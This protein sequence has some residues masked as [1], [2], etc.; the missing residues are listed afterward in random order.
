MDFL[1]ILVIHDYH[2]SMTSTLRSCM[3]MSSFP[4]PAELLTATSTCTRFC[5]LEN[6]KH[7]LASKRNVN[8][9]CY[10]P[11][12]STKCLQQEMERDMLL[13][14][15]TTGDIRVKMGSLLVI[16]TKD[17]S[18]STSAGQLDARRH[19]HKKKGSS[20]EIHHP[21]LQQRTKL[22]SWT[23]L[24][25][26]PIRLLFLLGSRR[27]FVTSSIQTIF[28]VPNAMTTLKQWSTVSSEKESTCILPF[29][30]P[31][32]HVITCPSFMW[33]EIHAY[34]EEFTLFLLWSMK[35]PMKMSKNFLLAKT[36]H[37]Q[38]LVW[39]ETLKW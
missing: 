33:L 21:L 23:G 7:H 19:R 9:P 34:M 10:Q 28:S 37:T 12:Q 11:Y 32:K 17:A 30:H 39:R 2:N 27:R 18:I 4:Q 6:N 16:T 8:W 13:V 14:R 15:S 5:S 22:S 29:V 24:E 38:N 3:Q 35:R 36:C 25:V 1:V 31:N 26:V 20:W